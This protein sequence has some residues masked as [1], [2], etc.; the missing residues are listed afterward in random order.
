MCAGIAQEFSG[1]AVEV[2]IVLCMTHIRTEAR[3]HLEALAERGYTVIP[4][5]VCA[6][7]AGEL[8][9]NVRHLHAERRRVPDNA[10]PFLNRGHDVLYNLQNEG[11]GFLQQF[12]RNALVMELLRGLLNDP[13]YKQIPA[14]RPNFLLRAM[15]ARSSG[16]SDLPLH[17]D[18]FVPSSGRHCIACQ[19]AIVLEDQS[20]ETGCTLVV[21]GSH[22]SDEYAHQDAMSRAIPLETR[23][24]DIVIW[25]GR[26]WHGALGNK[27]DRSRW[28]VIATFVR[29][30]MK[31]NFDIPGTLPQ[32][33][34]GVLD[35]DEKTMLGY[36][37][38]PPRDE[39]D[40]V[41]IKAGHGQLKARVADY[42]RP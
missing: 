26:L 24:G 11:V 2:C 19:V 12:S 18:S 8:L 32:S 7:T 10:Q 14:D 37:S 41:D 35:E 38:M 27:T 16:N 33:I 3:S 30:W 28:S 13:Y 5:G 4:G 39:F 20:R 21:P 15:A 36:C 6:S 17:I 40:R 42:G 9:S 23:A 25:D 1:D 22:R 31:H 29:W 34:Y